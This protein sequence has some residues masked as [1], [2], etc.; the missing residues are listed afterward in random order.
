MLDELAQ[1]NAPSMWAHRDAE[2]LRH[3]VDRED[4][5]DARQPGGIQ[6]A[7]VDRRCLEHLLEE[8]A[9][10]SMLAAGHADRRHRPPD[11]GVTEHVVRTGRF[12]DPQW[13]ELR[14]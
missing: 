14:E 4:L 8:H 3:E 12:L 7:V 11:R 5:V 1:A 2:L 10:H 6:L 9:V 13:S